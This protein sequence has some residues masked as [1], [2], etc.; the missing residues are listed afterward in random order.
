MLTRRLILV[1][2]LV[3]GSTIG[4]VVYSQAAGQADDVAEPA[5]PLPPWVRSDGTTD[6]EKMPPRVPVAGPD[7]E[8]LRNSD[9]SY[10]TV[11]RPGPPPAPPPFRSDSPQ[12]PVEARPGPGTE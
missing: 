2:S 10:V 7:G 1:V 4:M 3:L 6:F 12:F 9:G 5:P 8:I 11:E